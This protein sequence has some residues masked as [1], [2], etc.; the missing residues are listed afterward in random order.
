MKN[1]PKMIAG[2]IFCILIIAALSLFSRTEYGT[3]FFKRLLS[4]NAFILDGRDGW[5][6]YRGELD[7]AILPWTGVAAKLA[8]I[9]A[10]AKQNNVP[11]V[12]VPIPNKIDLYPE[13][14]DDRLHGLRY[15]RDR[16][17]RLFAT[18][19]NDKVNVVDLFDNYEKARDSVPIYDPDEAHVTSEGLK[20]AATETVRKFFA[21]LYAGPAACLGKRGSLFTICLPSNEM[22]RR[23]TGALTFIITPAGTHSI[24]QTRS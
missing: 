5:L 15:L 4:F 1:K 13:K 8:R 23:W 22:R 6:F 3:V 11:L 18:L 24:P 20:I 16:Y 7:Y 17:S 12:I 2:I 10:F 21:A 14:L 9:D 19:K